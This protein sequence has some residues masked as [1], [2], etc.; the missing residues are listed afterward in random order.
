MRIADDDRRRSMRRR[1]ARPAAVTTAGV[2]LAVTAGVVAP[3]Q[4]AAESDTKQVRCGGTVTAEPGDRIQGVTALGVPIDL[5]VVT[6]TLGTLLSGVCKVTVNVVDTAVRPLPG[7]GEPLADGVNGTVDDVTGGAKKLTDTLGGKQALPR[8]DDDP[9][10][11][12][13]DDDS[14]SDSGGDAGSG[15]D[16]PDG[17][18]SAGSGESDG[19]TG[20]RTPNSPVV[21][22]PG[23][24]DSGGGMSFAA[25]AGM[26]APPGLRYA[27]VPA[28]SGA[29]FEAA[30][31][32]RYGGQIPGYNPDFG[33]LGENAPSPNAAGPDIRALEQQDHG[34]E[35]GQAGRSDG[36]RT[37][38][39]AAALQSAAPDSPM[40]GPSL[41]LL[42]AVIALAGVSAGLV[43]TWV[44]QRP[45]T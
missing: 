44:L 35:A 41:P 40:N 29:V 30:P 19:D 16:E 18:D 13:P 5:G 9:A 42:L 24:G 25:P 27:G 22:Q 36:L 8:P 23:S 34:Q 1:A 6:D 43:R 15:G 2:L 26:S 7:A 12:D 38:G 28:A 10:P 39:D 20:H 32:L 31:G 17:D 4:A 14:G 3:G 45:S 11:S 21:D 33:V 37:A